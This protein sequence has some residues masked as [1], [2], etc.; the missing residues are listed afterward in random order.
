MTATRT[1]A[2]SHP[3][4]FGYYDHRWEAHRTW[5]KTLEHIPVSL[6]VVSMLE[7]LQC[8]A[9]TS[10]MSTIQGYITALSHRHRR[11]A[12]GSNITFS[13]LPSIKTWLSGLQR[14]QL[15][16]VRAVVCPP[17]TAYP[18]GVAGAQ[19]PLLLV[20]LV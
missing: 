11:V 9:E 1:L 17:A 8:K 7:F 3:D 10:A 20:S 14:N 4:C 18:R 2:T 12:V 19:P 15:L 5:R 6:P 13:R 16:R